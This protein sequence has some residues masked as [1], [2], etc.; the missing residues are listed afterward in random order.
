MLAT[1]VSTLIIGKRERQEN[2]RKCKEEEKTDADEKEGAQE[3]SLRNS[4]V[5][6]EERWHLGSRGYLWWHFHTSAHR[7][8]QLSASFVTCFPNKLVTTWRCRICCPPTMCVCVLRCVLVCVSDP[9][10]KKREHPG[11][12]YYSQWLPTMKSRRMMWVGMFEE[13]L[14]WRTSIG[15]SARRHSTKAVL[16]S[17]KYPR[18]ASPAPHV[19]PVWQY[20]LSRPD[21]HLLWKLLRRQ[22]ADHGKIGTS[23]CWSVENL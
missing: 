20:L 3:Q 5:S 19:P 23:A 8:R 15:A 13:C 22:S 12:Y 2:R 16:Y 14:E 21:G 17:A 4:E 7:K 1:A 10:N 11:W 9:F 6:R 18:P